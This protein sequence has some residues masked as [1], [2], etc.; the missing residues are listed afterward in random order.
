MCLCQALVATCGVWFPDWGLNLVPLHWKCRVL[1]TRRADE[2][3][4]L[5][6]DL[7]LPTVEVALWEGW[8]S[9]QAAEL[10]E[11]N[12]GSISDCQVS[13]R[14]EL[15]SEANPEKNRDKK[16]KD[17][18]NNLFFFFSQ[19]PDQAM[20][21]IL[22]FLKTHFILF[23][24]AVGFVAHSG[25]LRLKRTR[26]LSSCGMQA[27]HFDGGP[28]GGAQAPAAWTQSPQLRGSRALTQ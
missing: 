11:G 15:E 17:I 14:G 22:P 9:L 4:P 27:S 19:H 24:A 20:P 5:P 21:D 25:F 12:H 6:L 8:F 28:C 23:S 18:P 7:P 26:R 1:A 10:V 13:R 2:S 3:L 16:W